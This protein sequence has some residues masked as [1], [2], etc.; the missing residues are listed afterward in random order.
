VRLTIAIST[1]DGAPC[2]RRAVESALAQP[3]RD[4]EV[5]VSNNASTDETGSVLDAQCSQRSDPRFRVVHHE[6]RM[7]ITAHAGF[8]IGEARGA[9]F[10]GLSNDDWIEPA[11]APRVLSF[12]DCYPRFPFV[13]T[14]RLVHL[15]DLSLG[16]PA[17]PEL[18]EPLD[19]LA[20]YFTGARARP[21]YGV[22]GRDLDCAQLNHPGD[23][24]HLS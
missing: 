15:G 24:C 6:K 19:F 2:I 8:L 14:R 7:P 4:L 23:E 18:E 11:F 1:V 20:A 10:L 3:V 21:T 5:L 22:Y 13:Y 17:G 16:S 9:M 12:I